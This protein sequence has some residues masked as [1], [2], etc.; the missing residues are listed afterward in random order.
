MDNYES[1]RDLLYLELEKAFP[2]MTK[3]ER[4][5]ILQVIDTAMKD[6][7]I[8]RK[9]MDLIVYEEN[10]IPQIVKEFVG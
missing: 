10:G 2:D 5:K 8:T 6:Y 3:E 9:N 4:I 7:T 1:F